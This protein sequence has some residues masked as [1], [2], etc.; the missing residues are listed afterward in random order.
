MGDQREP[1]TGKDEGS[2]PRR[3]ARRKSGGKRQLA[4]SPAPTFV[5][6]LKQ[7]QNEWDAEELARR[8]PTLLVRHTMRSGQKVKFSGNVVVLGDVN[9]G[10]EVH[11]GGDIIVM[12]WLRGLAHAGGDSN[13]KAKVSAFRLDPTQLRIARHIGRAPD[14]G[15]GV[16]PDVPEVAEV[17]DGRLVIDR[18]QQSVLSGLQTTGQ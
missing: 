14:H 1:R 18:W 12:G 5:H 4:P 13:E 7:R 6:E 9:P 10:A 3:R 2:R 17:K 11:A 16:I 15:E 8:D